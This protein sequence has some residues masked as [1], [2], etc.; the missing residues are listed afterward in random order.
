MCHYVPPTFLS[1]GSICFPT[2]LLKY[3]LTEEVL[4]EAFSQSPDNACWSLHEIPT[5]GF[6]K[7]LYNFLRKWPHT[8]SMTKTR[9]GQFFMDIDPGLRQMTMSRRPG[10]ILRFIQNVV[11][12]I[13]AS[14][15]TNVI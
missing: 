10:N 15:S 6:Y 2:E 4:K 14:F 12:A 7:E 8:H 1:I 13:Q 3:G 5:V 9:M 11:R